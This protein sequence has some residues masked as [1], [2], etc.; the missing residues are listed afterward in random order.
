MKNKNNKYC[1]LSSR[2]FR[3]S[4]STA[5][6]ALSTGIQSRESGGC[7]LPLM[8][9]QEVPD[10]PLSS[11]LSY[12]CPAWEV[13]PPFSFMGSVILATLPVQGGPG[14][15]GSRA[16]GLCGRRPQKAGTFTS[17]NI[18]RQ[19]GQ[20]QNWVLCLHSLVLQQRLPERARL[21]A[22]KT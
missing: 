18:S 11:P 12:L 1:Y 7:P 17:S 8:L 6:P 16:G 20:L 19:M 14:N 15:L 2:G 13:W 22:D 3:H 4:V 21:K 10:C 5:F 9:C